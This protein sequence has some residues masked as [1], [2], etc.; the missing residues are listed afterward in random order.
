MRDEDRSTAEQSLL[1]LEAYFRAEHV[2]GGGS[3]LERSQFVFA[4][5]SVGVNRKVLETTTSLKHR[6]MLNTFCASEDCCLAA[7][8]V[9]HVPCRDLRRA[10][11]LV[12]RKIYEIFGKRQRILMEILNRAIGSISVIFPQILSKLSKFSE[13]HC[14]IHDVPAILRNFPQ[15]R[16]NSVKFEAKNA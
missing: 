8:L 10:K 9:D 3:R 6:A 13:I 2:R 1:L 15:F 4:M 7:S 12:L 11:H 5:K 14:K 16:Q